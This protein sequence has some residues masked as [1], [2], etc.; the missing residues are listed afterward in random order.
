MDPT[1]SQ[2]LIDKREA[3]QRHQLCEIDRSIIVTDPYCSI[4][5]YYPMRMRPPLFLLLASMALAQV[6]PTGALVG[7][8]SDSSGAVIPG[9]YRSAI[10]CPFHVTTKAAVFPSG[11]SNAASRAALSFAT[12][13][14][15]GSGWRDGWSR[16]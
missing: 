8:V 12:S 16:C 5:Y 13:S 10:S 14:P 15:E 7:E 1:Q 4:G 11:G 3:A 9:A 6:A 2:W